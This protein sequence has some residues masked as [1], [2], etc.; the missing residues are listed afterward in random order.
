MRSSISLLV[1]SSKVSRGEQE[2]S[3]CATIF[4]KHKVEPA[5]FRNTVIKFEYCWQNILYYI[6]DPT[7]ICTTLGLNVKILGWFPVLCQIQGISPID[8]T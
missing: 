8:F 2:D 5:S 1:N 7:K 4:M 3:E 6:Y